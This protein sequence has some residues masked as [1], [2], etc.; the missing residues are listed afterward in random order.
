MLSLNISPP[1]AFLKQGQ[2]FIQPVLT[3]DV[4]GQGAVCFWVSRNQSAWAPL[5]PD[6][7]DGSLPTEESQAGSKPITNGLAVGHYRFLGYLRQASNPNYDATL[8][9]PEPLVRA[10]LN[11]LR[12]GTTLLQDSPEQFGASGTQINSYARGIAGGEPTYAV[13]RVDRSEP[14]HPADLLPDGSPYPTSWLDFPSPDPNAITPPQPTAY[15]LPAVD[16]NIGVASRYFLPGQSYWALLLVYTEDGRWQVRKGKLTMYRRSVQIVLKEIS[17]SNDGGLGDTKASFKIWVVDRDMFASSCFLST[18][19]ISDRPDPGSEWMEHIALSVDCQVPIDM[20]PYAVSEDKYNRCAILTRAIGKHPT[21]TD[22]ISGNVR[23]QPGATPPDV[24]SY[25]ALLRFPIG[26]SIESFDDKKF[27][28][29]AA[30]VNPD[31]R[32]NEF[33]Y[34]VRGTYSV[35][36]EP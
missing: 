22:D 28:I 9:D 5:F 29:P 11:I 32:D 31:D 13:L 23:P 27:T 30:N 7:H 2:N 26:Q 33:A 35:S 36:Y 4:T 25:E 6:S 8:S 12:D 24:F 19:P 10:E 15:E 3:W 21:G 34:E 1:A 18:R 20:G 16:H 17:I 14:V